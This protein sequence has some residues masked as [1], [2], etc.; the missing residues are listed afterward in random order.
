[1]ERGNAPDLAREFDLSEVRV[2]QIYKRCLKE[3]RARTHPGECAV[4][5][6][7]VIAVPLVLALTLHEAAHAAAA[8]ALGDDTAYRAGRA[9][10]PNPFRH[11]DLVGSIA[12][13][14]LL[15]WCSSGTVILGYAKPVPVAFDRLRQRRRD[16][17][18]VVLA[19]PASNVLQAGV[20]LALAAL[21][22]EVDL[23]LEVARAGVWVNLMVAAFNL[24]P[25]PPLDGGRALLAG[26]SKS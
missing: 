12:L 6:F 19:G 9:C 24:L 8:L 23:L 20:W 14:A 10:S 1:M 18:L 3:Y 21:F 17:I 22:G 13:P 16:T 4:N 11:I 26:I 7:L 5:Q 15:F 25:I 2:H